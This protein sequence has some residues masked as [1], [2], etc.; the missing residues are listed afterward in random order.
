[1]RRHASLRLTDEQYRKL[2]AL[3]RRGG[4]SRGA[5]IRALI[6]AADGGQ[7]QQRK[8]AAAAA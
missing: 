5:I 1:M 2:T 4:R 8:P 3:A 7:G 6:E